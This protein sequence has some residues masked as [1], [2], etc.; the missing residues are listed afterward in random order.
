M[1]RREEVFRIGRMGKPHGVDGELQMQ[2]SD[3]VFDRVEAD[4]LVLD[5]DGILVPFFLE[6][7]RFR[8][9]EMALV[10]F[11]GINS[12]T[13]ARQLSLCEVFFPKR[14]ADD[15]API[16][17]WNSLL[18]YQILHAGT[19]DAVG[20]VQS[21]D[22]STANVLLYVSTPEGTTH[23]IPASP[24][25]MKDVDTRQRTILMDIPDG[26]LDL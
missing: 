9:D 3:D 16:A 15:D 5:I 20:E 17:N 23:I 26:L 10:K 1:I 2:F 7:Y 8:S 4:F 21:V 22:S 25:L 12:D 18:G 19:E 24:E 14:L 11:E 6:A 13:Q